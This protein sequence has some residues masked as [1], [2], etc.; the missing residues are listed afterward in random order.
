MQSKM[1]LNPPFRADHVGSL[2]RPPALQA[3]RRAFQMGQ[4]SKADLAIAEDTAIR[5]IVKIQQDAGLRG[6]SDGEQRRT[7]FHVDFLEQISG[8][9]SELAKYEIKFRGGNKDVT[10]V[11][12]ILTVTGKLQRTHGIATDDFRFLQS[13]VA[14]GLVPKVCIPSPTML[15]FRGG[16]KG[17]DEN[18]YPDLNEFFS[19]LARVFQQE[20]A[21]LY[22]LGCR[23]VHLDDTN[24][25]Y[26]C[27]PS[28]RERAKAQGEDPAALPALYA[29]LI[30][31]SVK[32][33]PADMTIGLHLCRGNHRSA[34]AAEGG[35]EAVADV[36]FNQCNVDT[37][38]L[39]YDDA[40]SGDFSPLRFLPKHKSVVLG[41]I[42]SKTPVL[43]SKDLIKRRIEEAIQ[44][45]ALDQCCLSP[46]CGFAST[47]EGNDLSF[48]EQ[49]AKLRLVVELAAEI[50]PD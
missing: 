36:M 28:H 16:R 48:A 44:Y 5:E 7:F 8:V 37:F 27:D 25:A 10:L 4:I 29:W 41:L 43:E 2:L 35:Y 42:C 49:A 46:Q 1:K 13:V 33:C 22:A 21:E 15:H 24:L 38:F 3:A 20:L 26:L 47:Y 12:P 45:I 34:W 50:W 32:L 30:S 31:E 19:D 11:P 39:E 17:I 23:Y 6:I 18:T 14:P 9:K 40:R